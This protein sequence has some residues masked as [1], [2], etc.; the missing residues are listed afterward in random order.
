[1]QVKALN[2][3]S[4]L[5]IAIQEMGSAEAAFDIA[6]ANNIG[7]TDDLQVGQTLQIPQSTNDYVRKQ[8]VN[9]YKI[10]NIKPATQ[11]QGI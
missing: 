1:M 11:W 6:L 4:L 3:Q 9:Y 5:D 8:I 7:V 10:N 2:N